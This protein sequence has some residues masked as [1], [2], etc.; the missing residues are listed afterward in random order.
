MPI[1]GYYRWVWGYV[2]PWEN[3][4]RYAYS[5]YFDRR[6]RWINNYFGIVTQILILCMGDMVWIN[7]PEEELFVTPPEG[8]MVIQKKGAA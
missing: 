1:Q 7:M 4:D 8:S 5:P 3:S 6:R 2:P